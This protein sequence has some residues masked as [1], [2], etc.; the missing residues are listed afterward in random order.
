MSYSHYDVAHRW[1][2]GIGDHCNGGSMYFVDDAIYSYGYHFCIAR[3]YRGKVLMTERTYSNSTAKHCGIV[4]GACR[5]YDVIRCAQVDSTPGTKYFISDNLSIWK[6]EVKSI[7]DGPMA[8]ARKPQKYLVEILAIVRKVEVFCKFFKVRVPK[9][10]TIYRDTMDKEAVLAAAKETAKKLA[11]KKRRKEAADAKK[12]MN[13]EKDYFNGDYQIVRL[14][15]D[16][17]RFE[18]S[19]HV[20]IPFEI[21]R[22]F[23]EK[24]KDGTLRVG[25]SC[26]Y[27][28]VRS[29]GN[30]IKVGCHTFKRKWLLD[31]GKKVFS[32]A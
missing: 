5:Q 8:K 28:K 19:Q 10:F 24:L 30:D 12:F 22:Q 9:E 20:Q 4:W 14:R 13:F 27:Y 32:L 15:K 31:Y 21:G 7:L 6:E 23:Y 18:T 2:N 11:E 25:D 17:N 26:L 3:K 1:A 29:V 16:K